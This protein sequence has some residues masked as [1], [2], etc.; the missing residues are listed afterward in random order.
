MEQVQPRGSDMYTHPSI[1]IQSH[2]IRLY[3][4]VES[5]GPAGVNSHCLYTRMGSYP[6]PNGPTT[7]VSPISASLRHF[8][9]HFYELRCKLSPLLL[10]ITT[11]FFS[12]ITIIIT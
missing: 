11:S 3:A 1:P 6:A 9:F 2:Q 4:S 8:P 10:L 7:Q 12:P 5:Y